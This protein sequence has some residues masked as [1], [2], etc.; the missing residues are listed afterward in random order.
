[1]NVQGY[2]E[3]GMRKETKKEKGTGKA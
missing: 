3:R 2:K 1:M